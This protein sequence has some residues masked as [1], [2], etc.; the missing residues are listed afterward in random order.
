MSTEFPIHRDAEPVCQR[1]IDF[2][3]ECAK[4]YP[5][6]VPAAPE[7]SQVPGTGEAPHIGIHPKA[8]PIFGDNTP[9][10]DLFGITLPEI[11]LDGF[12][13]ALMI[14]G[15]CAVFGLVSAGA[16][17][18][19]ANLLAWSPARLRNWTIGASV[20][21]PGSA[22]V[23]GGMDWSAPLTQFTAGAAELVS[24]NPAHGLAAMTVLLI[25]AAWLAAMIAF[26]NRRVR[27]ATN[28]LQSPAATERALW[29]RTQREQR[30]AARMSRYRLPFSTGGLNPQPVLGRLATESSQAPTKSR[31]RALL[32][33]TETRLI[34]PWIKFNEHGTAVASSGKG[35]ST[36]LN[37][38]A[39]SWFVTGWLRHQ[40]WWRPR[41]PGRPLVLVIDCN[42]GPESKK[43]ART[44]A[45]WFAALG[46]PADRIGVVGVEDTDPLHTQLNLWGIAD[47]DDLRSVLSAMISGGST[48]TTDTERY[49][50]N[51]RETLIHLVV[52]AP[53]KVVDGKPVGHN[54][55]RDWIEFLSRFDPVK[56]AKL[57]GGIWDDTVPWAG[58]A[59]VDREIASTMAGKQPVMDSARSEFGIL[60]RLLGDSFEGDK[61]VTDFDFLYI[62]LEGVKAADRARAQFAALG[63]MLEQLADKDHG[64]QALLAVDEFS[65]VSDGKTRAKAWVERLRKAGI[66]SWWFAQSWNGLGHDDDSRE[67]LVTAASG[68]SLLGGQEKGDKLAEIYGTRRDFD[69]SRKLIGGSQEGDEGNVQANDKLLVHPNRLRAMAKGDIV[70]VSGG[71]A[72]FGRVTPLDERQLSSLRPLPG[73]AQMQTVTPDPVSLAPVI[74]LRKHRHA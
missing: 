49:F 73:L 9:D 21:M 1:V 5:S 59:G 22:I 38:T 8:P 50:H 51:L 57:W 15:T 3:P 12:L 30:A 11:T 52:D 27:V 45:R 28:G 71:V 37:R 58:V 56:L 7:Q 14:A 47:L 33:G 74:D 61:Q 68:G 17:F 10:G 19:V 4:T 53:E 23:F 6:Q 69:L 40:Q 26:T 66:G 32:A 46:V 60:Y 18:L 16:I 35:K 64:R 48:P 54:P 24:G 13:D 34:V 25:P 63:C 41:R 39:V 20:A 70:H 36:L 55:P 65:A 29:L 72:R 62:I 31:T 2:R 42:G 67:A 44:M 43:S